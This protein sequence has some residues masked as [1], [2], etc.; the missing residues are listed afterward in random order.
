MVNNFFNKA[1][2]LF[3]FV[4][5]KFK[6]KIINLGC[7]CCYLPWTIGFEIVFLFVGNLLIG[8]TN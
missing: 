5:L 7:F 4:S 6:N 3:D 8:V 1:V 2:K